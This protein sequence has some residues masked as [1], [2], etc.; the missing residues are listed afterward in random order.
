MG[1]AVWRGRLSQRCCCGRVYFTLRDCLWI[2][3][4]PDAKRQHNLAKER[5]LNRAWCYLQCEHWL[6]YNLEKA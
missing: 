1:G 6:E 4:S 5:C 2:A 3:S